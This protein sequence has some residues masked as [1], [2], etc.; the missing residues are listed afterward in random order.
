MIEAIEMMKHILRARG[1][2]ADSLAHQR[3]SRWENCLDMPTPRYLDALCLL[4]RSRP[5]RL[6]FGHDYSD[7]EPISP[8]GLEITVD[9]RHFLG[10]AT[11]SAVVMPTMS[12]TSRASTGV[13]YIPS[14]GRAAAAHASLLEDMTEENGYG[15]Y[16]E[17]PAEFISARMVD[18][19]RIEACLLTATTSDIRHRLHRVLAKNAAFIAI[20]LNDV[21]GVEDT[22]DW[23]GIAR[24]AA[25]RS[26]DTAVEAWIAGH[27]CDACT[28]HG[29]AAKSGLV[30]ARVA[31]TAGD[32]RPHAAAVFGYLAEAGVQARMGRGRETLDA[33][34]NADRMFAALP[35]AQTVAD[36]LHVTEYFLRWHQSNALTAIGERR[37]AEV[38]RQRALDLPF[39][40]QDEVGGAL[41]RLDE[42]ASHMRDGEL[43]GGCRVIATAWNALPVE[44]RVGQIPRRVVQILDD[45][46]PVHARSREVRE[47]RELLESSVSN[48]G[49]TID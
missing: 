39:S 9:R 20:R 34:R 5:D 43:E 19:G 30:A 8:L 6:G 15:L 45:V 22:F 46:Q 49:A 25:R 11:V 29:R 37:Q 1:T 23:F 2:P 17:A 10:A 21:A 36:G 42:A 13:G 27:I 44:Y 12:S 32:S 16:T 48:S 40:R 35:E 41:L 3:L 26:G 4:Y 7:Q 24:R 38:L 14:D 18:L 31:Q 47:V 33:V 28:C